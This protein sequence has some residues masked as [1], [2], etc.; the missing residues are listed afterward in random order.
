MHGLEFFPAQAFQHIAV[1]DV[2][3]FQNSAQADGGEARRRE[4]AACLL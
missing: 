3:G 2:G 4:S 1:T